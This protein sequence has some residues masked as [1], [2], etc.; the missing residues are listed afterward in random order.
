VTRFRRSYLAALALCALVL[1]VAGAG[2]GLAKPADPPPLTG[3]LYG[4]HLVPDRALP[5]PEPIAL[6]AEE[7]TRWVEA[8]ASGVAALQQDPWTAI[9]QCVRDD[10][11]G[12]PED[13]SDD[14]PAASIAI[15]VDGVITYTK[16]YG[17]RDLQMGGEIDANTLF[18]IGSTTKMMTAA[19]IMQLREAGLIALDAPIT[20]Y[21]PEYQ[22]GH[23]WHSSDL[24]LDLLLSHQSGILDQYFITDL[25]MPLLTWVQTVGAYSLPLYAAPGSFWNYAN[26][27]FSLAGAVIEKVTGM[28]YKDYMATR[29]WGPAGMPLTTVDSTAVIST[30][31]YATGYNAGQPLDP[32]A[33]DLPFLGPAGTAFSTPSELVRWALLMQADR[34]DVISAES[35]RLM[36]ERHV[37]MGYLPWVDYGYGIMITDWRDAADPSH[38]VVVYDHGGNIYGGSS[39][40]YW[41]PERGVVVSILADTIRSLSNAA[42]CAVETLAGIEPI[43]SDSEKKDPD[44][45]GVHAG[46]YSM[47]DVVLTAWTASVHKVTDTLRLDF[48]DIYG[49]VV[50]MGSDMPMHYAYADTYVAG[51]RSV[52]LGPGGVDFEFIRDPQ[53]ASRVRYMR[54]RNVVGQ[55]VGQFPDRVTIEGE[56]CTPVS[57]KSELDMPLLTVEASGVV[58]PTSSLSMPLTADD[59]NDPGSAKIRQPITVGEG[60]A[61]WLYAKVETAPTSVTPLLLMRD[62][63]GDGQF[64]YPDE[65]FWSSAN[66]YGISVLYVAQALDPGSYELWLWGLS[67]PAEGSVADLQLTVM[68]GQ[69]LRLENQP[70]GLADGA[71]WQ[72]QVCATDMDG[73]DGPMTGAIQFSYDSPPRLFRIMVDWIPASAPPPI[74]LPLGLK[75][76]ALQ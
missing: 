13:D 7:V 59:P 65:L 25:H 14:T 55:R 61:L 62:E 12:D 51:A 73:F 26:P 58:S 5:E 9:D 57:F 60:G 23:P 56:S 32:K 4:D 11:A 52:L 63:D 30:G 34:D 42:A 69:H 10:M 17:V 53:D 22:L 54:N 1:A 28:P 39:Q 47:L 37:N 31:N 40:L 6:H 3:S 68:Q 38:R 74:F 64:V 50:L 44:T 18:R 24:N 41:V 48:P 49:S 72:M 46:T 71:E 2:L 19:A 45:W 16:G 33:W 21:V 27:N 43:P 20:E 15:A 8:H 36:Q 76:F 70:R 66:D 35:K 75:D 67:V 29:V